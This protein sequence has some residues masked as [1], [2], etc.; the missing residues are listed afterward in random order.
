MNDKLTEWLIAEVKTRGFSGILFFATLAAFVFVGL[1]M[2]LG[3]VLGI[4]KSLR[5]AEG[6]GPDNQKKRGD[7]LTTLEPQVTG[8]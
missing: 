4:R 7:L 6:L 3:W 5:E 1:G 8:H 2:A